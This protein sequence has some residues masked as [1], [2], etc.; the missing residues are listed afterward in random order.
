MKQYSYLAVGIIL[1]ITVCM[2]FV[3]CGGG[4]YKNRGLE[5]DMYCAINRYGKFV[6]QSTGTR[7][8]LVGDVTDAH[9][10]SHK[11]IP[12]YCLSFSSPY[13]HTLNEARV[14]ATKQVKQFWVMLQHD[15]EVNKYARRIHQD[16]SHF[17]EQPVLQLVGYKITYWD[18]NFE[19]RQKPYIA[20]MQFYREKFHYFYENKETHELELVFEESYEDALQFLK[21]EMSSKEKNG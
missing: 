16:L 3:S 17:P 19:R 18:E 5:K 2:A 21:K 14:F 6:A 10:Y 7:F 4:L 15:E 9:I 1:C 8:L 20:A 13:T 11:D 12:S